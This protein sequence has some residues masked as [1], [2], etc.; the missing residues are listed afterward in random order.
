M[1]ARSASSVR[2]S[3]SARVATTL[4]VRLLRRRTL[5]RALA[6]ALLAALLVQVVALVLL[7]RRLL[8]VGA[9]DLAEALRDRARVLMLVR[10]H[11]LVLVSD[12]HATHNIIYG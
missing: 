3:L 5:G 11:V 1:L 9:V 7:H 12:G 4:T 2:V 6:V 10:K 8:H